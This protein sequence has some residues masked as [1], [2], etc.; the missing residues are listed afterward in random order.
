L[1]GLASST[2]VRGGANTHR[3]VLVDLQLGITSAVSKNNVVGESCCPKEGANDSVIA[4]RCDIE[5]RAHPDTD[6]IVAG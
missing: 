4:S 3:T 1:Q 5:S 2:K 6:V